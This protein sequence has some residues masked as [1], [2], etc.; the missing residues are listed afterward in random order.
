MSLEGGD[1]NISTAG[2]TAADRRTTDVNNS[3]AGRNRRNADNSTTGTIAAVAGT[4]KS[5][6]A[7]NSR[8]VSNK[9]DA[10]SSRNAGNRIEKTTNQKFSGNSRKNKAS[11]TKILPIDF[12]QF[13]SYMNSEV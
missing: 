8:D 7:S 12:S 3:R 10:S 11:R 13:D 9:R 6:D 1:K 5:R 4:S 2:S